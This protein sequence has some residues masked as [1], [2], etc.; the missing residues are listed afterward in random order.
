MDIYEADIEFLEKVAKK[1]SEFPS[2]EVPDAFNSTM[3]KRYG[4]ERAMAII[5]DRRFED[6]DDTLNDVYMDLFVRESTCRQMKNKMH[7]QRAM[8]GVQALRSALQKRRQSGK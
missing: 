3:S 8:D 2:I 6:P 1:A 5:K 7:Y 4:I